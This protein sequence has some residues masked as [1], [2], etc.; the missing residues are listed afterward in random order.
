LCRPRKLGAAQVEA[1]KA[2]LGERPTATNDMIIAALEL[3][4]SNGSVS[5]YLKR[6]GFTRKKVHCRLFPRAGVQGDMF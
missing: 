3:P 1:L 5:N 2:H 4:I 6:E